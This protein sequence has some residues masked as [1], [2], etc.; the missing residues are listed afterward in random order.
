MAVNYLQQIN[1]TWSLLYTLADN[2]Q[3]CLVKFSIVSNNL[4]TGTH[5]LATFDTAAINFASQNS[6]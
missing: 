4:T 6:A 2:H 3:H 5:Q 1:D